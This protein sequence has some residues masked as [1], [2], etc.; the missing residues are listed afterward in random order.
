MTSIF[1]FNNASRAAGYGIGTYVRQLADGLRRAHDTRV[2]LVEMYAGTKE[3]AISDDEDGMRHYLIPSLNS[4]MENENYCRIIFYFLARN[5]D[6]NGCGRMVFLF[7]YFQHYPLA[8]LLKSCFPNSCIVLT[9][10]YMNWCFELKGNVRRM[11]A[12]TADGYEP[13]SDKEKELIASFSGE[14][15]FL[16]LADAVLVLSRRTKEILTVDYKVSNDK[17]HLVY[18]GTA[19]EVCRN[20]S[21]PAGKWLRRDILYVG[22]L[23]EIKGLK[24][25]ISAY[26]KVVDKY[27]DIHLVIVGD[28]DFQPYLEQC[29]KMQGRVSFLGKMQSGDV[30]S[31]YQSAYMGVMPSFHEQCSYTAIEMMRHGIPVIGTDST[32]LSEM[33]DAVPQLRVHIDEDEFS[34]DSFVSQIALRMD[35]LLSDNAAYRLASDAVQKQ[36]EKRYTLDAMIQGVSDAVLSFHEKSSPIVSADYLPHMDKQMTA[37]INR[38]PDIDMEF[39]GMAGIG[40]YLWWRMLQLEKNGGAGTSQYATIKENLTRYLDWVEAVIDDEPA[41][42]ELRAMLYSMKEHGF[43]PALA[44]R[45]LEHGG[46]DSE[47]LSFPS[48]EEI[49]HNALKICTCKI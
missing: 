1:I 22:R 44:E 17:M 24:Y 41:G 45:I 28:G 30:D 48:E 6:H 26:G 27:P 46:G 37:L 31:V 49:L 18:N 20:S 15:K 34:E 7:N 21:S 47:G 36:Y 19:G 3:L 35:M 16:H 2:S 13:K 43:C 25:L 33:L 38:H 10:H 11:K 40:I 8:A 29:R 42:E 39:Y 12:I 9:V 5:I 4:G 14:E 23:D 32:G